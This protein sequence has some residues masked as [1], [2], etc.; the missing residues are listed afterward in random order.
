M[1][2]FGA[3][4]AFGVKPSVVTFNALISACAK[5]GK[6]EDAL[7]LFNFTHL[8]KLYNAA[9]IYFLL[10]LQSYCGIFKQYRKNVP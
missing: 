3:M 7:R 8:L 9:E 4:N 5:N 2:V 1:R 6:V 10:E